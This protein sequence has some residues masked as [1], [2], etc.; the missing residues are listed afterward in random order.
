MSSIFCKQC[1]LERKNHSVDELIECTLLLIKG[2][3]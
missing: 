2:I 1:Y 3:Q